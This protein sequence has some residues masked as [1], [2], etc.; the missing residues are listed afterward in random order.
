MSDVDRDVELLSLG[1]PAIRRTPSG[2]SDTSSKR[3]LPESPPRS[4]VTLK[5]PKVTRAGRGT[6]G[7]GI[8]GNKTAEG[9]R[10]QLDPRGV[11]LGN[12]TVPEESEVS[13]TVDIDSNKVRE[14]VRRLWTTLTLP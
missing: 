4:D 6:E 9:T 10:L 2:A 12:I 1:P 3:G 7:V 14:L 8:A 5:R 11:N 13:E